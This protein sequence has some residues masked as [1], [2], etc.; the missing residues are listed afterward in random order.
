MP[1]DDALRDEATSIDGG[2]DLD[3]QGASVLEFP[4]DGAQ[5]VVVDAR[6]VTFLDSAGI[7]ALVT[8]YHRV[9][10]HGAALRRVVKPDT[11]PRR[12]LQIAQ[13][14]ELIAFYIDRDQGVNPRGDRRTR[15][16]E[17]AYRHA[18]KASRSGLRGGSSSEQGTGE[19][20][21][22]TPAGRHGS[23]APDSSL[24]PVSTS[25]E[26]DRVVDSLS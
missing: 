11:M 18:A 5:V 16:G 6:H 26:A 24:P 17:P 25:A 9:S 7:G 21:P 1:F 4:I 10:S 19:G 15:R 20:R 23:T 3:L 14:G 22:R 8:L 12:V 2:D 13:I